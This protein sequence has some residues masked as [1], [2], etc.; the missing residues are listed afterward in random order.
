M[1][2]LFDEWRGRTHRHSMDPIVDPLGGVRPQPLPDPEVTAGPS[3]EPF[4]GCNV[5]DGDRYL[6]TEPVGGTTVRLTL[7]CDSC[8]TRTEI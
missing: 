6:R 3:L 2:E 8:G 1:F 5:C 4:S 7:V